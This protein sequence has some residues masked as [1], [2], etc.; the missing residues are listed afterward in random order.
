MDE[1]SRDDLQRVLGAFRR[2][3][4]RV[5]PLAGGLIHRTYA[6][7]AHD[8]EHVLQRV[9]PIF[10][11]DV[12]ENMVAVT[13]HLR[14]R[15][16]AA[17]SLHLS[18][19]GRPWYADS[20]LGVWRLMS[21]LRGRPISRVETPSQARELGA[22]LGRFHQALAD[23]AHPFRA[24]RLAGHD[25]RR[26]ESVL[27]RALTQHAEH[28]LVRDVARLVTEIGAELEQLRPLDERRTQLGHGDPKLA[29]VLFDG[30]ATAL[31]DLDTVGP[32]AMALEWGDAWR[33]WCMS[34]A[35]D[36]SEPEFR[37]EVFAQAWEGWRGHAMSPLTAAQLD[38]LLLAPE[39]IA[40]ELS[41]RFAAD[42]LNETYFGWDASR[43]ATAGEHNFA[44]A[45]SQVRSSRSMRRSRHER[46][47][48]MGVRPS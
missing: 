10:D 15:G 46:A 40:L 34:G 9:S 13:D 36:D 37:L 25:R 19:Q 2:E 35:E 22:V 24:L 3:G 31:I 27:R 5:E 48:I 44:R 12:H 32:V 6:V 1:P 8:G 41:L 43:Y 26:H 18:E 21:R 7:W 38:E 30:E 14:A 39:W 23:C 33:S 42:A 17:P 4:A 45:R 47:R 29:N 16:V 20:G 28:Q 11:P